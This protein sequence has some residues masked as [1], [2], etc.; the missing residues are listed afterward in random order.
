MIKPSQFGIVVYRDKYIQIVIQEFFALQEIDLDSV[1]L[2]NALHMSEKC[3][4]ISIN[5]TVTYT[6]GSYV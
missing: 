5:I 6:N 4:F 1:V 2:L 3:Y